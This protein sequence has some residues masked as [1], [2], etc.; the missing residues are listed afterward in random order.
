MNPRPTLFNHLDV[1]GVLGEGLNVS[2]HGDDGVESRGWLGKAYLL[3]E[4]DGFV[5]HRSGTFEV[6]REI[7]L[8]RWVIADGRKGKC[9]RKAETDSLRE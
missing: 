1:E 4:T 2:S 3:R 6:P 8:S 9:N 5:A 7:R